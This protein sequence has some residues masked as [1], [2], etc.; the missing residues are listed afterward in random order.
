MSDTDTAKTGDDLAA[1]RS[2]FIEKV[3]LIAQSKG[4]PRIA[5]RVFA[6][7]VFDGETVSFADLATRLG[8]SRG[9]VSSATRLL[10]DRGMIKRVGKPG[11]RQDF[12]RLADDPYES[13][14]AAEAA[15]LERARAEIGATLEQ[16]PDGCAGIWQRVEGYARFYERM[17]EALSGAEPSDHS[18]R[19]QQG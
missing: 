14:L 19:R 3:G 17:V 15:S 8:V 16:L 5:G 1:I 10:E 2:E 18:S 6:L 9:S 7:L 4:L 13:M 11:Q 12:F